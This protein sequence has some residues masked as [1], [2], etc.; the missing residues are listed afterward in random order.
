METAQKLDTKAIVAGWT[1]AMTDMYCKD[2]KAMT[3]EQLVAAQPGVARAASVLTGDACAMAIYAT[4]LIND[5]TTEFQ[6]EADMNRLVG[7]MTTV[8]EAVRVVSETGSALASAIE[9]ASDERMAE[10]MTPPWGG[11]A[12]PMFLF[13]NIAANHLW[14]HDGQINLIQAMNGDGEVHWMDQ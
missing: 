4:N 1:R 6:M 2:L 13:A 7:E 10:M 5:P 11:P 12:M 8:A 3:D 14:Y 9:G